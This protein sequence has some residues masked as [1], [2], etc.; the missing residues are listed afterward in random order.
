[1]PMVEDRFVAAPDGRQLHC[2]VYGRPTDHLPVLG[3]PGLT[4][5][6]RDFE[7][8]APGWAHDRLVVALSL[9][10]RG[11]SEVDPTAESYGLDT[12]VGDVE[13]VLDAFGLDRVVLVGT[14][15]G[16]LVALWAAHRLPER[17][18]GMVINDIG[19]ELQPEGLARIQGYAGKLPPVQDWPG[20]VAQA[21]L[22]GE[23]AYP[24]WGDA[25]WDHF[26]HLVYRE[27][28]DGRPVLDHDPAVASGRLAED[29]PW[30]V[31]ASSADRPLLLVRGALTDL[32]APTTVEQMQALHPGMEVVE[33]AGRGHAPTLGEPDAAEAVQRFLDQF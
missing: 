17:V 23:Q 6:N 31:F 8:V 1:M 32:L 5:T 21:R 11:R 13:A 3:L 10:G 27:D 18:A 25:E 30:V 19:P 12:Y 15:L 16:G 33:V 22:T 24:D 9:R 14:S 29:D 26:A 7:H 2:A 4:R 20:A 28:A